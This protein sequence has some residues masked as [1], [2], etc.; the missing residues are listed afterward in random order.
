M[1]EPTPA[2]EPAQWRWALHYI[3]AVAWADGALGEIER[4]YLQHLIETHTAPDDAEAINWLLQPPPAPDW[5]ALKADPERAVYVLKLA[6][7]MSMAD[8]NVAFEEMTV[9]QTLAT[10]SGLSE[11][12]FYGVLREAQEHVAK[13]IAARQAADA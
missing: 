12:T 3:A 9:L 2:T 7:M 1:S 6:T 11:D 4:Q 5:D 8:L 10:R 13:S